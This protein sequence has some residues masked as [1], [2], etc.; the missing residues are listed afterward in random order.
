MRIFRIESDP[1]IYREEQQDGF[2]TVSLVDLVRHMHPYSLRVAV[3]KKGSLRNVK[4]LQE[5]D[6]FVDVVGDDDTEETPLG[7]PVASTLFDLGSEQ[8]VPHPQTPA[9]SSAAH[10]AQVC[11]EDM[12]KLCMPNSGEQEEEDAAAHRVLSKAGTCGRR[13]K[14]VRFAPDLASIHMYQVEDEANEGDVPDA[15]SSADHTDDLKMADSQASALSGN[16]TEAKKTPSQNGNTKLKTLS[17]QEYRLLRQKMLPQ[18]AKKTDFRTKWPSVPKTPKELPPIPCMPGYNS[19]QVNV[20]TASSNIKTPTPGA[21]ARSRRSL[22]LPLKSFPKQNALVRM[23]VQDVDPPNPVIVPLWSDAKILPPLSEEQ[24]EIG[25]FQANQ[26]NLNLPSAVQNSNVRT[27]LSKC[28]R[29]VSAI[30]KT[31]ISAPSSSPVSILPMQASQGSLPQVQIPVPNHCAE[32][33]RQESTGEIGNL[34]RSMVQFIQKFLVLFQTI[35]YINLLDCKSYIVLCEKA[36]GLSHS[37]NSIMFFSFVFN[38]MSTIHP[39][40]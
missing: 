17:L 5:E 15:L 29:T 4:E 19:S 10:N 27:P 9:V 35:I 7:M 2:V 40:A 36:Q 39:L 14:K 1:E 30:V 13:K 3:D 8:I 23:P 20:Q 26:T 33:K 38:T 24:K 16:S 18:E 28:S 31:N 11:Q 6:V 37:F 32:E 22:H 25:K 12:L 21:L 34:I